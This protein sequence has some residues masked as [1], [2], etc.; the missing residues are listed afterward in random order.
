MNKYHVSVTLWGHHHHLIIG[1][2]AVCATRLRDP[3]IAE[4]E[5]DCRKYKSSKLFL[6]PA[7]DVP[8]QY[9]SKSAQCS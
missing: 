9:S 1:A 2:A 7:P 4:A 3:H 8:G 6:L 5:I